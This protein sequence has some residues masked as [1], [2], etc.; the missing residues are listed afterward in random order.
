MSK[1]NQYDKEV[2]LKQ[3]NFR[4][5]LEGNI[6]S[7]ATITIK[8]CWC[9]SHLSSCQMIQHWP[10]IKPTVV[11]IVER[12]MGKAK[13]LIQIQIFDLHRKKFL[14]KPNDSGTNLNEELA[15]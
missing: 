7:T 3:R 8:P 9:N 2:L 12:M 13:C 10:N 6:G 11:E 14:V 5:I 1:E 15:D 4:E